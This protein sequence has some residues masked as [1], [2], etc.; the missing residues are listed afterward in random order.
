MKSHDVIMRISLVVVSVVGLYGGAAY[1]QFTEGTTFLF[2]DVPGSDPGN[3]LIGRQ[4]LAFSIN[5]LA[6][7]QV[8]FTFQNVGTS[9]SSV[10][11]VFFDDL[12]T[13]M[14]L[15]LD[16]TTFAGTGVAFDRPTTAVD[17]P[18]GHP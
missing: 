6:D 14:L 8:G 12:T 5:E 18:G 7:N 10:T 15:S 16:D 9:P 17:F 4:Q 11:G 3:A 2:S 1:A 13:P